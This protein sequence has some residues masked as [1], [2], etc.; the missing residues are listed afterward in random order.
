MR[1]FSFIFSFLS[2]LWEHCNAKRINCLYDFLFSI[3]AASINISKIVNIKIGNQM[4]PQVNTNFFWYEECLEIS[5]F[6]IISL[7]AKVDSVNPKN[8]LY[9]CHEHTYPGHEESLE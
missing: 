4:F 5:K 8:R 1:T 6:L 2:F 7:I 3:N 9:Q